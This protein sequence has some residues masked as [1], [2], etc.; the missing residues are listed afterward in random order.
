VTLERALLQRGEE[1]AVVGGVGGVV[2]SHAAGDVAGHRLERD[3]AR[4]RAPV[5][6]PDAVGHHHQQRHPLA[7]GGELAGIGQAGELDLGLPA[8]RADEELVLVVGPDP[9][10]VGQPE[11]V[12]LVVA[13]LAVGGR[14][15]HG[16][17]A[18]HGDLGA[19]ALARP[20]EA[21]AVADSRDTTR[22]AGDVAKMAP[23]PRSG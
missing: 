15:R 9:A 2:R 21:D 12:D 22:V 4:L 5:P 17:V 13:R 19:A 18:G 23:E 11:D 7:P 1:L 16:G 10:G 20:V 8:E 3:A 14:E 6:G